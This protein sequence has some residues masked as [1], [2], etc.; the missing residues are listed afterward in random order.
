MYSVA[1][2]SDDFVAAMA[3]NGLR[4]VIASSPPSTC[5]AAVPHRAWPLTRSSARISSA[6]FQ[7]AQRHA[8]LGHRPSAAATLPQDRRGTASDAGSLTAFMGNKCLDTIGATKFWM[9]F[10]RSKTLHGTR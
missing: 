7:R 9:P 3:Y 8:V 2:L 5:T 6:I 1:G 10:I 4:T